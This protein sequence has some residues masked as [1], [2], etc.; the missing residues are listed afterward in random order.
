MRNGFFWVD[1]NKENIDFFHI[2]SAYQT[3]RNWE[4]DYEEKHGKAFDE[5]AFQSKFLANSKVIWYEVAKEEKSQALFERLNLGKIP[6]TNAE[7]TKALFLS[8]NSFNTFSEKRDS[9]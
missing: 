2:S 7:L 3:I 4:L 1:I 5:A 6:L 8:S 9:R